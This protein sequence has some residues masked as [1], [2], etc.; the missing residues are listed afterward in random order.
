MLGVN[1]AASGHVRPSPEQVRVMICYSLQDGNAEPSGHVDD[2]RDTLC[3]NKVMQRD[4]RWWSVL[5]R[6]TGT[7][8]DRFAVSNSRPFPIL[9]RPS[10]EQ[11]G[12]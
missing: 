6:H 8:L 9:A 7:A 10:E 12:G 4:G 3:G 11:A 2:E 5:R 1:A